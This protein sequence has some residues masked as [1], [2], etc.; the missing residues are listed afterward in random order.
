MKMTIIFLALLSV[1]VGQA[2]QSPK[3][4]SDSSE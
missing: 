3:T 2:A 1:G 4:R